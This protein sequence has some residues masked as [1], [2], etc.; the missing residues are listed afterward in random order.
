M[1]KEKYKEVIVEAISNGDGVSDQTGNFTAEEI[2]VIVN[3]YLKTFEEVA[4][5][6]NYPKGVTHKVYKELD[7][8]E[9]VE[10]GLDEPKLPYN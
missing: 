9:V 6:F 8:K 4:I 2:A 3:T 1:K 5:V 10:M 7:A